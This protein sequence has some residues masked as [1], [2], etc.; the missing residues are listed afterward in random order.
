MKQSPGGFAQKKLKNVTKFTKNH[1]RQSLIFKKVVDCRLV[2][3]FSGEFWKYLFWN[4]F[5]AE[6]W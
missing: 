1:L 4:S 2:Q 6:H 5:I 3:V